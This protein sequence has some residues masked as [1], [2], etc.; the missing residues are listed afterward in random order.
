ML[1][2]HGDGRHQFEVWCDLEG[3]GGWTLALLKNSAHSDP[4]FMQGIYAFGVE[5]SFTDLLGADPALV[6]HS[7]YGDPAIT[8]MNLSGLTYEH[9]RLTAWS[10]GRRTYTS[11]AIP[12]DALNLRFGQSGYY[13][14]EADADPPRADG[15]TYTWCAGDA[16]FMDDGRGQSNQ[17][18]GAPDDCK[19]HSNIGG[20]W[21]F[22]RAVSRD[23]G[24]TVSDRDHDSFM[25][26]D[27]GGER[28]DLGTSG[29]AQALWVR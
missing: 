20:G 8:W 4:L 15:Q 19:G 2:L 18:P 3:D 28:I 16:S 23:A 11:S 22:S 27:Y 6:S 12:R 1:D 17:P 10:D 29:A 24:L 9:L 5:W 26:N 21:D 14:Y 7:D 25:T 13:L